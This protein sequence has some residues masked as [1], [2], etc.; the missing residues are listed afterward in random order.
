MTMLRPGGCVREYVCYKN[1]MKMK[2]IWFCYMFYITFLLALLFYMYECILLETK[3]HSYILR[4]EKNVKK[5]SLILQEADDE[6]DSDLY[7]SLKKKE[8]TFNVISW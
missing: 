1:E 8:I 3:S 6:V 4:M 7:S 5:F 2:K